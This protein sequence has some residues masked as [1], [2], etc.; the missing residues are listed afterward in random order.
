MQI[1]YE[2]TEDDYTRFNLNH[3]KRSK[4]SKRM[5]ILQRTIGPIMFLGASFVLATWLQET[6]WWWYGTYGVASILWFLY[7]PKYFE[8]HVRKQTRRLIGERGNEGMIGPHTMNLDEDGLRDVNEFG[9]TRASWAGIK[10]VVE[11]DDYVYLYNSSVSA[12]I[13]PKRGL[14]MEEV[15]RWL[16][17]R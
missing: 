8:R 17:T 6:G 10:E 4:T 2:L 1:Q 16:P 5:L 14:D 15:R 7:Y 3:I 9:E 11:E 13:L 12:H